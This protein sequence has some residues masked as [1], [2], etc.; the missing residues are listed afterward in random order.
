MQ[1]Q[2]LFIL[3]RRLNRKPEMKKHFVDFMQKMFEKDP[4]KPAPPLKEGE[5]CWYIPCFGVYHPRKPDQIRVVFESSARH[6][7]VSLNDNLTG[8]NLNNNLTGVLLRFRQEPIAFMADIQQMFHCFIVH[9]DCRN[10]LRFRW[11][12]NNVVN[13]EVIYYRMK[14]HVFSNSPSPTVAIYGLRKTTQEG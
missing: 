5:E 14:V 2:G 10:F 8:P 7:G 9:E 4:A 3:K 1:N 13:D 11:C 12:H 6:E